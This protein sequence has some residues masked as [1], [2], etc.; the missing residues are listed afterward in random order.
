MRISHRLA[1]LRETRSRISQTGPHDTMA[2]MGSE[3]AKG[4]AAESW[5]YWLAI[6]PTTLCL[7]A[8]A[9]AGASA[10]EAPYAMVNH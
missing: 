10:G 1:D 7:S 5:H 2:P 9:S 8:S 6:L 4:R 3:A